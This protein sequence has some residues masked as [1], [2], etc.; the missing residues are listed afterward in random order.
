LLSVLQQSTWG[1]GS[2]LG[3]GGHQA[4]IGEAQAKEKNK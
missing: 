1:G 3:G 2:P 4:P